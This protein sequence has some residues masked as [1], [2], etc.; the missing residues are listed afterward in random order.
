MAPFERRRSNTSR[1]R[2]SEP[3][4]AWF[5][6]GWLG[7]WVTARMME[8]GEK[9]GQLT[10]RAL[11][12]QGDSPWNPGWI[13][14][15]CGPC[16]PTL[17]WV[18]FRVWVRVGLELASREGWVGT[19]PATGLD[20]NCLGSKIHLQVKHCG[21]YLHWISS[22]NVALPLLPI[23]VYFPPSLL[24]M[25]LMTRKYFAPSCSTWGRWLLSVVFTLLP[26][27][28]SQRRNCSFV[29]VQGMRLLD[30]ELPLSLVKV[31]TAAPETMSRPFYSC[32]LCGQAFA[33]KRGL[34]WLYTFCC[35]LT[36]L[37][38]TEEG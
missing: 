2:S 6:E 26:F 19:W 25:S 38:L 4:T 29:T 24:F 10:V 35:S 32:V 21:W 34:S 28:S 31:W 17:P 20:P 36:Q 12:L 9:K 13:V 15:T 8:P 18:R 1:K 16:I 37:T 14:G 23:Q 11:A 30:P 33:Q 7:H 3:M 27:G 5:W 22:S